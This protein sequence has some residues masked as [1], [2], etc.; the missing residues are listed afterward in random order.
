MAPLSAKQI[1]DNNRSSGQPKMGPG[2]H[3]SIDFTG[4][5]IEEGKHV[6]LNFMNEDD[7]IQNRRIWWYDPEKVYPR[8]SE[9]D[10]EA[11]ERDQKERLA[12]LSDLLRI[13]LPKEEFE[14]FEYP[15]FD[16]FARKAV[17]ELNK[18]RDKKKVNIKL[19]PDSSLRYSEFP[20]YGKWVEEYEEGKPHGLSYSK[21]ELKNRINVTNPS[22]SSD[23]PVVG[24]DSEEQYELF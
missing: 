8:D 2:F 17:V 12:P 1:Y 11:R 9:S 4:A 14:K 3:V 7:K 10:E 6:D 15:T 5:D 22:L 23:N 13:F 24:G 21:W 19:I 18:Y 20:R 16:A